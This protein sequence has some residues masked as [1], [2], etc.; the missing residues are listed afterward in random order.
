[1]CEEKMRPEFDWLPGSGLLL[2][3][4]GVVGAIPLIGALQALRELNRG[5]VT[6][7]VARAADFCLGVADVSIARRFVLRR[8]IFVRDFPEQVEGLVQ[9]NA[10]TG[11]D[12]ENFTAG[13]EGFTG[14]KVGL[15]SIFD[16]RKVA[17]LLAVAIDERLAVLKES[18]G[19]PG[20]HAGIRGIGILPWAKDVEVA[21]TNTLEAVTAQKSLGV[22]L[23]DIFR[24]AI[25]GDRRGLHIF[26][27]RK[28]GGLAV[29]GRGGGKNDALD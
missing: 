29:G 27:L 6:E 22:E 20:K 5:F 9:R 26:G 24:D 16:E 10:G 23:A 13:T 8:K 1:A 7:D 3:F 17:G 14:E 2:D 25:G 11:T 28:S 19:E 4:P 15:N 12:V 21:Q 18:G